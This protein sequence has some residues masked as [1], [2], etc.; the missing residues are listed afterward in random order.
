MS[1]SVDKEV[2]KFEIL[3]AQK[4]FEERGLEE[5]AGW[6]DI[7]ILRFINKF[8]VLNCEL[9]KLANKP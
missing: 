3:K 4:Q 6:W 8:S 2:I 1:E 7:N 9:Y 5:G